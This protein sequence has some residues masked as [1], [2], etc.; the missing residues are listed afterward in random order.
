MVIKVN[1]KGAHVTISWISKDPYTSD[2]PYRAIG[3]GYEVPLDPTPQSMDEVDLIDQYAGDGNLVLNLDEG[4]SYIFSFIFH[5]K[6]I[7]FGDKAAATRMTTLAFM[8]S[9]PLGE[10]KRDTLAR[11]ESEGFTPNQKIKSEIRGYLDRMRSFDS[12]VRE[13]IR[14][15]KAQNLPPDEEE[16]KLSEFR[17]VTAGMKDK[18]EL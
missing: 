12:M 10:E 11:V 17:D 4:A 1:R 13:G 2:N 7:D 3:K 5:P 16:E 18:F 14:E 8:V 9:I 6:D 15:I